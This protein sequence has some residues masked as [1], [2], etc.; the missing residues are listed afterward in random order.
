MYGP[1][2]ENSEEKILNAKKG[3]GTKR[4]LFNFMSCKKF[5]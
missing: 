3:E 5:I 4:F 2:G 1:M